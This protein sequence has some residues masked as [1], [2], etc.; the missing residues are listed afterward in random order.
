MSKKLDVNERDLM[1]LSLFSNG[2]DREYY[3]REICTYIPVSHGTAQTILAHLEKK[4]VL[5]SSMRGKTRI[6]RIKPGEVSIQYFILAE[7]Y[8]K[9]CFMEEKPYISEIMHKITGLTR[10]ITL[11]FGSYAKGCEKEDSDLDIF[12]AGSYDDREATKM[13][14]LYDIEVNIQ[15][16]PADAFT[17]GNRS[18]P[19]VREVKKNH[20][21]WKNAESFVR[22]V[23]T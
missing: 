14:R 18:D 5:S 21:V 1:V 7:I 19:L 4:S 20:I 8:K 22:E 15:A 2:Y 23:M 17:S 3:I 10:G 9:I 13:G 12:I 6:F 16:Y 11:L